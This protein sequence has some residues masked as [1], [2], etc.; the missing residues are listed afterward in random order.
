MNLLSLRQKVTAAN[1]ANVDTPG[2]KTKDVTFQD[3][4]TVA[5]ST[6]RPEVTEVDGLVPKSDGNNVSL[7]REAQNLAEN[8]L[9]FSAAAQFL[10]TQIGLTRKALA[11]SR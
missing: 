1:I 7:D 4:L 3:L 6:V 8:A 10:Q 5:D 2:Y 11:E 9:R